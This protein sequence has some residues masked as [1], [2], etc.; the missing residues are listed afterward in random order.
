MC[1]RKGD[2]ET[3]RSIGFC[4]SLWCSRIHGSRGAVWSSARALA[5]RG[6]WNGGVSQAMIQFQ[7]R[8]FLPNHPTWYI[9]YEFW[10]DSRLTFLQYPI[11]DVLLLLTV[12]G[13]VSYCIGLKKIDL[14]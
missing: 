8:S 2:Q 9:A 12:N 5:I 10:I 13:R 3:L 4:E 1:E 14:S 6:A 11:P 7:N